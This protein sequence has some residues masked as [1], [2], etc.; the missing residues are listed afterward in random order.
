MPTVG[1]LRKRGS[2][3][4]LPNQANYLSIAN[5]VI[6]RLQDSATMETFRDIEPL[7]RKLE[8]VRPRYPQ[9]ADDKY[10]GF[11]L[12]ITD[13]HRTPLDEFELSVNRHKADGIF[14]IAVFWFRDPWLESFMEQALWIG[15]IEGYTS[16]F[17]PNRSDSNKVPRIG[18][19]VFNLEESRQF[20][21]SSLQKWV[22]FITQSSRQEQSV[23]ILVTKR[24]LDR[25]LCGIKAKSLMD[26]KDKI[27]WPQAIEK[28]NGKPHKWSL[29]QIRDAIKNSTRK[30]KESIVGILPTS[31]AEIRMLLTGKEAH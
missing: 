9:M 28:P 5:E 11:R 29:G 24:E 4:N 7:T 8:E 2:M 21:I 20:A 3:N 30:D 10:P 1:S 25:L 19:R 13:E 27:D 17:G 31:N 26:D 15:K 23:D 18:F 22:R 16:V 12:F 6:S 14:E